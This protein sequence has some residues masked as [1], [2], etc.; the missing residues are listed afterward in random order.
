MAFRRHKLNKK[1]LFYKPKKVLVSLD[2]AQ[3]G[4]ILI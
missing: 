2:N 1:F 4:Q 3:T